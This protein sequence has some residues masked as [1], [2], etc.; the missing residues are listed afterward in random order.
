MA[1]E[2]A[3][4]EAYLAGRRRRLTPQV[5]A[6]EYGASFADVANSSW[7]WSKED[8]DALIVPNEERS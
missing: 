7:L 4:D 3:L 1:G 6:M 5:Y 2:D 8:W